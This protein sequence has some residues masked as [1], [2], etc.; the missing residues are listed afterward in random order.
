MTT[1]DF[2][3]TVAVKDGY[4][5]DTHSCGDGKVTINNQ[6]EMLVGSL[7]TVCINDSQRDVTRSYMSFDTSS[8]PD[9]ATISAASLFVYFVGRVKPKIFTWSGI[10]DQRLALWVNDDVIGAALDDSDWKLGGT[11]I[12]NS[13]AFKNWITAGWKEFTGVESYV[14]KT[15][16]TDFM[17]NPNPDWSTDCQDSVKHYYLRWNTVEQT[18]PNLK[19]YLRVTYTVPSG[20][21]FTTIIGAS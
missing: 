12:Y 10:L 6:N 19:P 21:V 17:L 8:I 3:T 2:T 7:T 18:F 13:A 20:R 5:R 9:N 14:N 1:T 4:I 16:D 11:K 15:G